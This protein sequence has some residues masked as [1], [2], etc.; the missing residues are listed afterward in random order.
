MPAFMSGKSCVEDIPSLGETR[1]GRSLD[2]STVDL[3][4]PEK[5]KAARQRKRGKEYTVHKSRV[6]RILDWTLLLHTYVP[7]LML[8]AVSLLTVQ[9]SYEIWMNQ[10][11]IGDTY[12]A[13]LQ[14]RVFRHSPDRVV[15]L[16]VGWK[17][18]AVLVV[19]LWMFLRGRRPVYLIDFA[20]FEPPDSWKLTHDEIVE[21]VRRQKIYTDES[22]EF[23]VR[24]WLLLL[25]NV[26]NEF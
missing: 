3:R 12:S 10:L 19:I 2:I 4:K 21:I 23:M 7:Y 24:G 20:V 1:T 16:G 25:C 17:A 5:M 6:L 18:T 13:I 9:L 22:V 11:A 26:T 14:S 8:C 15:L